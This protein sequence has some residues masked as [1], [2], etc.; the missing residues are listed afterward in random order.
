MARLGSRTLSACGLDGCSF[1]G[2]DAAH[3]RGNLSV[4]LCGFDSAVRF[5]SCN[6]LGAMETLPRVLQHACFSACSLHSLRFV[7]S[8][9]A[10]IR[11]FDNRCTCGLAPHCSHRRSL[12]DALVG[13][14]RSTHL[15]RS[16]WSSSMNWRHYAI[17]FGIGL[18]VPFTVSRFQS[19][20]GYMDADYYF[21][22]GV[23][24]AEGHGFTEPYLWNYLDDPVSLPH[25][26]HTYWMRSEEHTS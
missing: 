2:S 21:S 4:Q 1:T 19:L 14:A 25:P 10:C 15:V 5:D 9:G 6:G 11:P 16:A 22:G 24:L 8:N 26:S 3:G 17:L 18:I 23:Q 13:S 12:L 7:H 20:P